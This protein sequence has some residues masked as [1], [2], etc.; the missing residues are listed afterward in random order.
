[1]FPS[2][3]TLPPTA[4]PHGS[5]SGAASS[6]STTPAPGSQLAVQG[7]LTSRTTATNTMQPRFA[8]PSHVTQA[9]S[10]APRSVPNLQASVRLAAYYPAALTLGLD[11]R[12]QAIFNDFRQAAT[13]QWR[14]VRYELHP[15]HSTL[16]FAA[17]STAGGVLDV[18][19]NVRR[20]QVLR[21]RIENR[22]T[23]EVINLQCPA[24]Q[25]A[26]PP[27]QATELAVRLVLDTPMAPNL[28]QGLTTPQLAIVAD[29]LGAPDSRRL[30]QR[31][32]QSTG[33]ATDFEFSIHT[34]QGIGTRRPAVYRVSGTAR[35]NQ[36]DQCTI[37]ERNSNQALTLPAAAPAQPL[38][39][40]PQQL[41]AGNSVPVAN[42]S[43]LFAAQA[44][45]DS[46]VEQTQP[47]VFPG[48][49]LTAPM[50]TNPPGSDDGTGD[51]DPFGSQPRQ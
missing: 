1:M 29:V 16:Q 51:T 30:L 24:T 19:M 18:S 46:S 42:I 9:L 50:S 41:S 3:R 21:L 33:Q 13:A 14:G 35:N 7:G 43:V 8:V 2:S 17:P 45:I 27:G 31:Y 38:A 49:N 23:E 34:P 37:T 11:A 5:A 40:Q 36:I 44:P 4:G 6:A 47:V 10:Q 12:S 48:Q 25:A 15:T 32:D 28:V 22:N 26:R 20:G 39:F